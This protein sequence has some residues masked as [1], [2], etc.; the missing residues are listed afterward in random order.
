[1]V[2]YK[3]EFLL[4]E[5]IEKLNKKFSEELIKI[6]NIPLKLNIIQMKLI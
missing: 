1:M 3:R 5:S 2:F 6:N 4:N